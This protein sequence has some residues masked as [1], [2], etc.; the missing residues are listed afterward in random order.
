MNTPNCEQAAERQFDSFCKKVLRN[1][2]AGHIREV[3]RIRRYE[4]PLDELPA[5][6]TARLVSWDSYPSECFV[7]TFLGYEL[8]IRSDAVADAFA[9]LKTIDQSIL[10]LD[11]VLGLSN[12]KIGKII[13]LSR[14]SVQRRKA[15]ALQRLR[16]LLEQPTKGEK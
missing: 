4:V 15:D 8:P 5:E 12:R 3:Q 9:S 7:F 14:S 10:I 11:L 6:D 1:E 13:G 16:E 2:A